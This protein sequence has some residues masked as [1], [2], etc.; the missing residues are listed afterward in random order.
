MNTEGDYF[1]EYFTLAQTDALTDR[2][3]RMIELRYGFMG[4]DPHTLEEIGQEFGV[5]RE[6]ARQILKKSHRKILSRGQRQVKSGRAD[7]PCAQLHLFVQ[8]VIRPKDDG[9]IDRL[10][11]FVED[12]LHYLPVSTHALPL[13]TY[14]AY[15]SQKSAKLPMAEARKL[16]WERE[17]ARRKSY[18]R[19]KQHEKFQ[20]LLSYVVWPGEVRLL[21]GE[22]IATIRRERNVSVSGGGNAGVFHSN[23]M[24]RAV[25]YESE[26]E[27]D[28]L[29]RLEQ[30]DEVV[31]Y[32]EQPFKIPYE[33]DSQK[34]V[35]YPD[36]L[37]VLK[38]GRGVVVEIKPIF[39]MALQENLIKWAALRKFCAK[40]GL[41]IL[42]T[43]GRYSI[44]QVQ[45]QEV[46]P[47]FAN[48]VLA[49]LRQGP[50]S[51][52]QY[53]DIRDKYNVSRNEFLALILKNRLVWKLSPFTLSVHD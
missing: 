10:V 45:R 12:T 14:L 51:W 26:T 27:L 8:S 28:F 34:C 39:K 15:Q 32:Q 43:D 17:F 18:R 4:G 42:I 38:D 44:Q 53:K 23:K 3:S 13:V 1:A 40:N 46:K 21:E 50:L 29:L 11:N 30:L 22:E 9:A 2:E 41:G 47:E 35:Y 5:S 49:S 24:N 48:A 7:E 19:R 33:L 36:I 37:F 31:F 6:R 20:S 25:E 52:I 16:I